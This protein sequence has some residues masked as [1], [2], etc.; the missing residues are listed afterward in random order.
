MGQNAINNRASGIME[1]EE[2]TPLDKYRWKY[3][4]RHVF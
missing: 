3:F 2:I 4:R 1:V